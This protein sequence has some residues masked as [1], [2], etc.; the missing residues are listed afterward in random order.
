MSDISGASVDLHKALGGSADLQKVLGGSADLHKT[1][2]GSTD[3]HKVSGA[4]VIAQADD[5]NNVQMF[6]H[7]D[8][9]SD[10]V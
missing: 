4:M 2:G 8:G 10:V 3:W 7:W 9:N 6:T 1:S 5:G